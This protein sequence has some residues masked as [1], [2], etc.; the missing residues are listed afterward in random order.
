MTYDDIQSLVESV[1]GWMDR[2][3]MKWLYQ[4]ATNILSNGI[5]VEVGSWKGR[6]ASAIMKGLQTQNFFCI[7]KWSGNTGD[8]EDGY[9][10]IGLRAYNEFIDNTK[11]V[12]NKVPFII[13]ADSSKSSALFENKSIDWVFIDANHLADDVENDVRSWI[14]KLKE[15]GILSGHDYYKE[16]GEIPKALDRI[17]ELR[18]LELT[19]CNIWFNNLDKI[20]FK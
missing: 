6:S 2:P 12:C 17:L 9:E 7:D 4:T 14:P 18:T 11:R 19:G 13:T 20:R 1:E 10:G 16:G 15:N 8:Y 3:D 5:V